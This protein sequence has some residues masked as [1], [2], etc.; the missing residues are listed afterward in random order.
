MKKIFRWAALEVLSV[1]LDMM[2]M[3]I[4]S[5]DPQSEILMRI[6]MMRETIAKAR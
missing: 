6:Q 5:G 4:K 3:A 2:E 1:D